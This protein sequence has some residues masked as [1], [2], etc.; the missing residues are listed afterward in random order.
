[1]RH[2]LDLE[3]GW[4]EEEAKEEARQE[5][6]I[7]LEFDDSLKG[8]QAQIEEETKQEITVTQDRFSVGKS[9]CRRIAGVSV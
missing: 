9:A 1:M 3:F 8:E 2:K 5:I 7:Y 6:L 4:I